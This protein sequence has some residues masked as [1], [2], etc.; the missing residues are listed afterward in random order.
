MNIVKQKQIVMT[1]EEVLKQ[2]RK[3]N[4]RTNR[5]LLYCYQCTTGK[6]NVINDKIKEH[7]WCMEMY[8]DDCGATWC[9]CKQCS[10]AR[11]WLKTPKQIGQHERTQ[12]KPPPKAPRSN[13]RQSIA[14]ATLASGVSQDDDEEL[15]NDKQ[16]WIAVP[17]KSNLGFAEGPMQVFFQFMFA[18]S[19]K[20]HELPCL[21]GLEYLVKRSE[22][23]QEFNP[24][25]ADTCY[26]PPQ[27]VIL[28]CRIAELAFQHTST[29]RDSFV[30]TCLGIYKL[31]CEDGY[32]TAAEAI[33]ENFN[34]EV[35]GEDGKCTNYIRDHLMPKYSDDSVSSSRY[36]WGIR[37]PSTVND[38]RHGYL[39]SPDS[40][41][42]NLPHPKVMSD[43]ENHAYV[44]II[45][46]LRLFCALPDSELCKDYGFPSKDGTI[47]YVSQSPRALEIFEKARSY[48][49][50][51]GIELKFVSGI[52]FWGDDCD[53]GSSG[54]QGRANVWLKT[55]TIVNPF[56]DTNRIQNTFPI[57]IGSKS[58]SHEDIEEKINA[59]LKRLANPICLDPFYIGAVKKQ[60][61]CYFHVEY[62]SGDQP[63]RRNRIYFMEGNSK[64]CARFGVSADHGYLYEKLRP[65]SL[66][67]KLMKEKLERDDWITEVPHCSKCLN[68]N[69]IDRSDGLNL[70]PV[71]AKYPITMNPD[72]SFN[73]VPQGRL[74]RRGTEVFLQP[75][76]VTFKSM[77]EALDLAHH[78]YLNKNWN[79]GQCEV[80]L[81]VEGINLDLIK[82]FRQHANR[83]NVL[84]EADDELKAELLNENPEMFA[85][86]PK[87][88]T[89]LRSGVE[90]KH[91]L[92]AMMHLLFHGV[93]KDTTV[94]I[95]DTLTRK[96]ANSSFATMVKGHLKPLLE[97]KCNWLK[98][99]Q[100]GLGNYIAENYLAYARIAPWLYQNYEEAFPDVN[101]E[102]DKPEPDL[103]LKKWTAKNLKYWLRVRGLKVNGDKVALLSRVQRYIEG[104]EEEP[105]LLS[106]PN[107]SLDDI[108]ELVS[109]LHQLLKC[110]MSHKAV[111]RC[112]VMEL[113]ASV[114][115]FIT[116]F[117]NIDRELRKPE[118]KERVLRKPNF[119][120]LLNLP[121]MLENYGP[122]P[123]LWEGKIQGE[124]Y[125][126]CVKSTYYGGMLKSDKW[127]LHMLE[128]LYKEKCFNFLL[129]KDKSKKSD[130]RE[131]HSLR[132]RSRDFHKHSC[133]DDVKERIDETS[134]NQKKPVGVILVHDSSTSTG[135]P[136][137]QTRLFAVLSGGHLDLVEIQVENMTQP[138]AKC[139]FD[140]FKFNVVSFEDEVLTWEKLVSSLAKP[141]LGYGILLPLLDPRKE[142]ECGRMFALIS[143]TWVSL[144]H[145]N[146]LSD[147]ILYV[148]E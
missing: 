142:N 39:E 22:Y 99:R 146:D 106:I 117:D 43:I 134:L 49:L 88:S 50:S 119:L 58:A 76:V 36:E 108:S 62:E 25:L 53:A 60:C 148:E 95:D 38:L 24:K 129:N 112:R 44:S 31:G 102:K 12:H 66:C 120:C 33:N 47:S 23:H 56:G 14:A 61:H 45:D 101:P 137:K 90:M 133:Y 6:G 123:Y 65:C 89:W 84:A 147:L 105:P 109:S 9:V 27:Q 2:I 8:C 91:H 86:V 75:F 17:L 51:N 78:G 74:V 145:K 18:S 126:P 92:E 114:K 15:A 37:I 136:Q 42:K 97:I 52:R 135:D 69:A 130:I 59:D 79:I 98:L 144:S 71:P 124:G 5:Q 4:L 48:G 96:Y 140:Y 63:E 19:K 73:N 115:V 40:F 29:E 57:A 28:K 128:A 103:P 143:S 125:L 141:Q 41:I 100:Y 85:R 118:D 30:K 104:E 46:V 64:Y 10:G 116:A 16:G 72:G 139:G 32:H 94:L 127:Q 54:M 111:T 77:D 81:K 82:R 113:E 87:P 110:C 80:F 35:D 13:S 93:T 131:L 67:Y 70:T 121:S 7:S 1:H 34:Q 68:W 3:G 107:I 20:C 21:P 55:L 132:Q 83:A 11:S 122:L 26:I 138:F